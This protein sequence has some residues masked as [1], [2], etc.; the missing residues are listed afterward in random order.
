VNHDSIEVV[1]I[2][3]FGGATTLT[4]TIPEG[5]YSK[6]IPVAPATQ[7]SIYAPLPVVTGDHEWILITEK[8]VLPGT[9]VW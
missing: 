5:D 7:Q 4:G 1:A 2:Q 8:F 6:F 9:E 3:T